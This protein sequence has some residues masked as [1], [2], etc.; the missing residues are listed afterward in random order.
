LTSLQIER[1]FMNRVILKLKDRKGTVDVKICKKCNKEYKE[2]DNFNWSCCTHQ[3]DYSGEI[4]WCCGRTEKDARGCKYA[5][6]MKQPDEDE[7]Q[8]QVKAKVQQSC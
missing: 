7:D 5:K 8:L 1:S 3:S 6:H 2:K 4:W